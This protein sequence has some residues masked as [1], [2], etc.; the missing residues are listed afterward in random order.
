MLEIM[1]RLIEMINRR[2]NANES[3]QLT[4][5][6]IPHYMPPEEEEFHQ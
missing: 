3:N 2:S 6:E 1:N 5:D 4:Q